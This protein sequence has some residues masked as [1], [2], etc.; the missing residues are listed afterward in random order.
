MFPVLADLAS[1]IVTVN[2]PAK[3]PGVGFR[4]LAA[5]SNDLRAATRVDGSSG[6]CGTKADNDGSSGGG[7]SGGGSSSGSGSSTSST[8]NT[9]VPVEICVGGSD[10]DAVPLA[11]IVVCEL[12]DT[13]RAPPSVTAVLVAL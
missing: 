1:R 9:V 10:L 13:V 2:K 4:V 12:F 5:S 7:G 8:S 11:D 3:F 6:E